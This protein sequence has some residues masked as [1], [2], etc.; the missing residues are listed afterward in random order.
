MAKKPTSD[1]L[2]EA[3]V[4][5]QAVS[6]DLKGQKSSVMESGNYFNAPF[7]SDDLTYR[8]VGVHGLKQ[9]SGWV[10]EEYNP[11]LQGREAQRTYRE[12]RDGCA[13][14]SAIIFAIRQVLRKVE[15]RVIPADTSSGALKEAEFVES[16][17]DD[18]DHT[19][20]EFVSSALTMLEYGFSVH[21]IVYKKRNGPQKPRTEG[22]R[23]PE[24]GSKYTDGRVGIGELASRGQDTI[25]KWFFDP[26]GKI[27]GVTQQPYT[28]G[29][30]DIPIEKFLLF[31][32]MAHKNNP[33]GYSILRASV[34]PWYF[35]KRLEEG[36]AIYLWR[37]SGVPV[38]SI[39]IQISDAAAS[40]DSNAQ[41]TLQAWKDLVTRTS[42]DEQMGIV[43]PSD[44][45][46][47]AN[48]PTPQPMYKFELVTPSGGKANTDFNVPIERYKLDI[49][50]T[51]LCDFIQMGHSS[52]GTQGLSL[53]KVDMFYAAIKGWIDSIADQLNR[54]LL[55][56]LWELN[57]LNPDHMPTISPD[58]SQRI[59]LDSLGAFILNLSQSGMPL[60]PDK[61]LE[62]YLRDIAGVPPVMDNTTVAADV[63][64]QQTQAED[65]R[66]M[67][68]AAALATMMPTPQQPQGKTPA[69][70][71]KKGGRPMGNS[72]H[73]NTQLKKL[74]EMILEKMGAT[75]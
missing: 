4:S 16:I 1:A 71:P 52:R 73:Q 60:F 53:N 64:Q 19:W 63:T 6:P 34:R 23:M 61:A 13:I 62:E 68:E 45:Y 65:D 36:E 56:K 18:M 27:L 74:L 12:M 10:R 5:G 8:N 46:E 54:V 51:T 31:R 67:A 66:K 58:V 48:G 44:C 3:A 41:A 20:D 17:M 32:P 55:P 72:P 25:L 21:E 70:A 35:L 75:E 11:K 39:P 22:N 42:I 26:N 43:L 47:G 29:L 37:M 15:W 2:K 38:V 40:G 7:M 50:Y 14:V 59:D 57:A 30:I 49:L 9:Y 69:D 33:E 24:P 28:G